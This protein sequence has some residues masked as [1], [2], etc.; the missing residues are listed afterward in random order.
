MK[1]VLL[2][3]CVLTV[4]SVGAYALDGVDVLTGQ[5][6]AKLK[7]QSGDTIVAR[8]DAIPLYVGFRFDAKPFLEKFNIESAGRWDFV[9][10]PFI[11]AVFKPSANVEIGSNFLLE[12]AFP[13]TEKLHPYLKGGLGMLWMS[14][15]TREQGTQYNFLP[16][17]AA[18][19]HYFINDTAAITCE[20]RFR[21]L[22]NNSFK[23]P[24]RGIDS[25]IVVGGISFFFE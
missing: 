20:Y 5:L 11:S 15:H 17:M 2:I 25:D 1:K 9:I 12:Y 18:G 6:R 16:Q 3:V 23:E 19:I 8:Y 24:N 4:F 7:D 14:H 22:S 10:E 13:L 21:H